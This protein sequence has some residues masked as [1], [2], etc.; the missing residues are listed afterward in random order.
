L[1]AQ[2]NHLL[3]LDN[4][5]LSPENELLQEFIKCKDSQTVEKVRNHLK[6]KKIVLDDAKKLFGQPTEFT[7]WVF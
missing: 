2:K 3:H 1:L 5:S 4:Q 7:N 6:S